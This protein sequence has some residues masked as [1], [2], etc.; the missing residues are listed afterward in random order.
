MKLTFLGK[1]PNSGQGECPSVF[2]TDRRT[3]RCSGME[4][5]RP[6]SSDRIDRTWSARQR[7]RGGD[8]DRVASPLPGTM[9][10]RISRA[11][12]GELV[13]TFR[14]SARRLETRRNYVVENEQ[15]P[16]RRFLA[17]EPDDYTWFRPWLDQ[18]RQRTSRGSA[19]SRVRVVPETLTDYL[20]FELDICRHNVAAGEDVRYLPTARAR[21]LNLPDYDYYL[22]DDETLA[23][24]CF[25]GDDVPDGAHVVT[26]PAIVTSHRGWLDQAAEAAFTYEEYVRME[27]MRG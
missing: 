22:F 21:R 24:M 11:E 9:T 19:F 16:L 17:G 10:G 3:P 14:R 13:R 1:D 5:H 12:L 4:G 23:L 7:D 20:R 15:E 18:I 25:T 2:V 27:T 6:G 26:D 8:P